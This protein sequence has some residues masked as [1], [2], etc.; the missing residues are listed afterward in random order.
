[1]KATGKSRILNVRNDPPDDRDREYRPALVRLKSETDN[2]DPKLVLDQGTEGACTGFGL[3]AVVDVL[4]HARGNGS[5]E[6]SPRMF[7]EM[8]KKH[9]EWPGE[10]YAGSSCRGAIRGWRNM[11]VCSA[12]EWPYKANAPGSLTIARAIRA[13]ENTLGAYYRLR[14][15]ISDYH[16][17]INEVGA[18]Y[19]S[20]R[21]MKV[22]PPQRRHQ[23]ASCRSSISAPR[24]RAAMLSPSSVT[25]TA[26]LLSRIPGTKAGVARDSRSG[27]T[28]IGARTSWMAGF[29][30]SPCQHPKYSA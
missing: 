8:A 21:I 29:F 27:P 10:E 15:E 12:K 1:M 30:A 24:S 4:N 20:A 22:G 6:A 2:R 23:R 7:Y 13:R 14:P 11:G 25:P 28:R 16:A 5:F 17:A 3:A 19:V 18:I 9:D 26:V